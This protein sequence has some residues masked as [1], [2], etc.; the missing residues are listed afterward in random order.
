MKAHPPLRY[1]QATLDLLQAA[2]LVSPTAVEAINH[3]Q[4]RLRVP[5]PASVREWYS[6]RAATAWLAE[7]SNDDYPIPVEQFTAVE[8][9]R[10]GRSADK[11]ARAQPELMPILHE[12]QYVWMWALQLT[13]TEDPPVVVALQQSGPWTHWHWEPYAD[14]FSTF[15]YTRVWDYQ[16]LFS[17]HALWG[18]TRCTAEE[19][20]FLQAH[21]IEEPHT[22]TY[23]T[24]ITYRFAQGS[25]RVLLW[26]DEAGRTSWTLSAASEDALEH[27]LDTIGSCGALAEGVPDLARFER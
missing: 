11:Q 20:R 13:G 3:L 10:E 7:Y 21:F 5:L 12:N 26:Y 25:E 19:L 2:P 8:S 17:G 14:T 18:D 24:Q 22:V 4:N 23:P 9:S 6:L 1:H 27:L 15:V 16:G